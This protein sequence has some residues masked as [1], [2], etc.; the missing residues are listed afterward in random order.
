M[1]KYSFLFFLALIAI[2]YGQSV[3][4]IPAD[5]QSDAKAIPSDTKAIPTGIPNT[6]D[7]V[8]TA[9]AAPS[10]PKT[11]KAPPS[12]FLASIT[13]INQAK[14]TKTVPPEILTQ[15]SQASAAA[16]AT[17]KIGG[18]AGDNSANVSSVNALK[19]SG[20]FFAFVVAYIMS[21]F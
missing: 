2:A 16:T 10:A 7:A 6:G 4:T 12:E 5:I 8:T 14:A 1:N 18:A 13:T 19:I 11:S 20:T 21:L 3:K 9:K 17:N 15:A